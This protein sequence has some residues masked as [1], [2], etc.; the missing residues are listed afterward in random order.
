MPPPPLLTE[1]LPGFRAWELRD[2]GT[3]WPA[4]VGE[5][6]WEP[7]VNAARCERGGAHEA[8][9][10]GCTC[11]LYAFHSMHRQLAP[12][13]VVGAIA[14]WGA[15]EV[16]R[17][18]FRAGR[19]A[20]LALATRGRASAALRRAA[21]R[22][23]VP[24]VPRDVLQPVAALRTGLL[25]AALLD[26]PA[27]ARPHWLSRRR[28]YDP[29][30]QVW[31]E[32]GGGVVTLGI[33]ARLLEWLGPGLRVEAPAALPAALRLAGARHSLALPVAVA[34]PVVAVNAAPET[35]E[36]AADAE[37]TAWL[38]RVAPAA[39]ERDAAAF[40][41]GP[42]GRA[43]TLGVADAAAGHFDRLAGQEPPER[44]VAS[45]RDVAA[46]LRA[47]RERARAP[48]WASAGELYDDLG[49]AL[50]RALAEDPAGREHL[51]RLGTVL[52][53]EVSGPPARL[54]LDLRPGGGLSCGAGGPAADVTVGVTGEDLPALLGGR[55]DLAREARTRRLEIAGPLPVALTALAPV[56]AWARRRLA[57]A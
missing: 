55:L 6:A 53:I 50:G 52:A 15:M 35:A 21:E 36:G 37:G 44:P 12:E 8:P 33:S 5:R 32:P 26:L 7:G 20:V 16:H 13:R 39:W 23:G 40:D 28:G 38:L 30:A 17:D 10:A 14:A 3:L 1:A 19:A 9:G 41:W 54:V 46:V 45:W 43:A 49:I 34:G 48:R 42:A 4:A 18:G 27:S 25:P 29:H 2:D 47:E 24:L 56:T 22:Y 57:L 11:G 51:E 31:V